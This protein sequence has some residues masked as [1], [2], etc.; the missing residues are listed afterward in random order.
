MVI[1]L[2]YRETQFKR[3]TSA[4]NYRYVYI[5]GLLYLSPE[6]LYFALYSVS[7]IAYQCSKARRLQIVNKKFHGFLYIS[8][9]IIHKFLHKNS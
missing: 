4:V 5:L 7:P 3:P 8:K 2:Q 9:L 6:R 1:L